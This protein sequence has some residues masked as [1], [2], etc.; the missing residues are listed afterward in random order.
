MASFSTVVIV[1]HLGRDPDLKSFPTGGSV[2]TFSVA[3]NGTKKDEPVTWMRVQIWDKQAET[4]ATYL[5]KGSQV[6]VD[7]RLQTREWMGK[8]GEKKTET[9]VNARKVEFLGIK[10]ERKPPADPIEP[11]PDFG[12]TDPNDVPF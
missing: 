10:A 3:V 8:D 7:G 6:L 9:F 1:G 2:C 12:L 11:P 5:T 4:C